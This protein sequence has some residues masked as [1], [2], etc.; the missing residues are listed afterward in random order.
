MKEKH[1]EFF[2]GYDFIERETGKVMPELNCLNKII[3]ALELAE[4]EK[5][6]IQERG[7]GAT[8]MTPEE[9]AK[10]IAEEMLVRAKRGE[11]F[12]D[13]CV[14]SLTLNPT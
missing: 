2:P 3:K 9:T 10:K 1:E 11:E 13:R 4:V 12:Y 7:R 14:I 6:F 8:R 5:I